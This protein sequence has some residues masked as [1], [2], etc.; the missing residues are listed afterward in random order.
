MV[1]WQIQ[2][3]L[4]IRPQI[5]S[6][7]RILIG[8]NVTI[9]TGAGM[10][11]ASGLPDFRSAKQGLWGKIDPMT[12]AT[13]NCLR[14]NYDKF[15]EF[16]KMRLDGLNGV[17]PNRGHYIIADLE[18]QGKLNGLI[19]QNVDGLHQ[20]AGSQVVAALHGNLRYIFCE[21]CRTDATIEDFKA[22]KSCQKCGGHLRPG[23][24]LFG[25]NLPRDAMDKA[26]AWA[27][28]CKAFIVLGSSLQVSPANFYPRMA[29][30]HSAKL[31]IIN[32][33]ETPLDGIADLVIR[34]PIVEVLEETEK[35]MKQL[36]S[37]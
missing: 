11:T 36:G 25:E 7:S 17:L 32:Q 13:T 6:L 31:V 18:K 29:K 24:V 27:E 22:D 1:K 15:R 9:F 23:V 8:G 3:S 4:Q 5:E 16:Y 12:V 14:T 35:A 33:E 28:S 30:E 37:Q 10:S 34:D 21:S 26:S 20:Q 2:M 19:T